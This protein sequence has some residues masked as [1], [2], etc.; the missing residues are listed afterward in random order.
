[1]RPSTLALTVLAFAAPA[2]ATAGQPFLTDDPVPT[3][4]GHWQIFAPQF[5]AA[6]SGRNFEGVLETEIDYGAAPGVQLTLDFGSAYVHGARCWHWGLGDVRASLKYRFYDDDS[7]FQVA[8]FPGLTMPTGAQG[9]SA[10]RVTAFMPIWAQKD[11]G[12]WSLFG[13]GGYALNPGSGNRDYWTGG[14][15][16]TRQVNDGLLMG[17]ELQ[18]Q[19]ADTIGGAGSTSAGVGAIVHVVGPL[20]FHISGGPT[21]SDGGG[22]GFHAFTALALDF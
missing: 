6:G 18:R 22:E 1:L 9:I 17:V 15:A 14:L 8:A 5:V 7:G 16:V 10:G 20:S 2:T 12:P 11:W 3:D 19:G 4:T 13:G 21:W